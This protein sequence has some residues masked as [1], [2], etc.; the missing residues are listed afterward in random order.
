MQF[1]GIE[2][3]R[4]LR[5]EEQSVVRSFDVGHEKQIGVG[6]LFKQGMGTE[7]T[8][9]VFPYYSICYVIKGYG[10]YTDHKGR[11]YELSPG[12]VFQRFPDC[13]HSSSIEVGNDWVE[14]YLDFD[15]SSFE[16]FVTTGVISKEQPCIQGSPSTGIVT[17]L[18]EL[19]RDL[20]SYPQAELPDLLIRGAT[21]LRDMQQPDVKVD[22]SKSFIKLSSEYF[23]VHYQQ[24]IDIQQ[25][26][27]EHGKGYE[28]FRKT[29]KQ[30][31]GVSPRQYIVRR[32]MDVACQ[33]LRYSTQ[34]IKQIALVLGYSSAS[35]F[36]SQFK[37]TLGQSPQQYRQGHIIKSN[38]I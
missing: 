21:I 26:C 23:S 28:W 32:R 6:F 19:M 4:N 34:S 30:T 5:Q 2:S 14:C 31:V 9:Y 7:F 22:S 11:T 33:H 36:S 8:D 16:F 20:K 24:R 15:R 38:T 25:Y 10:K 35:D 29:F 13:N 27:L 18:F 37:S 12:C 17:A 1:L 3:L